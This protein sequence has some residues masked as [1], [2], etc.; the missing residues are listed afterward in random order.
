MEYVKVYFFFSSPSAPH[1]VESNNAEFGD[2][3]S[4]DEEHVSRKLMMPILEYMS[5]QEGFLE[6][7]V[8][9]HEYI[10]PFLFTHN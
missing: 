8:V 9:N 1:P 10:S 5:Y 7:V 6:S 3:S 4:V 2:M